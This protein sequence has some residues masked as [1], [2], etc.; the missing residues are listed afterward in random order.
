MKKA[1]RN[2]YYITPDESFSLLVAPITLYIL[3]MC[4]V[5]VYVN[6]FE[7][8]S[9][10]MVKVVS[11]LIFLTNHKLLY[12]ILKEHCKLNTFTN[13]QLNQNKLDN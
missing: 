7:Y 10:D 8:F 3:L 12:L 6:T 13:G 9:T 2:V 11:S 5:I 4:I 1:I